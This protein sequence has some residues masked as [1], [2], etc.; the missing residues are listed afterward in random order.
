MNIVYLTTEAIPFARTGGLGDVCGSLPNRVCNLGH[1][2]SVFL[3]AFRS[4]HNAGIPVVPTDISFMIEMKPG[5]PVGCRLLRSELPNSGVTV[6]FIDQPKYFDR[7]ELYGIKSGD[8][9]DNAERFAF[10]S[11]ATIK[12]IQRLQIQPDIVHCNDWQSGLIPGLVRKNDRVSQYFDKTATVMTIHN[13]AYQG[14]FPAKNFEFTGLSWEHFSPNSFEFYQHLNFLKSGIICADTVTT[15]SPQYAAEIKTSRYGCGLE[16]VLKASSS[17][18][19]GIINGIDE[20]IWNPTS[21]TLL[22]YH[23]DAS[24]WLIGKQANKQHLQ[25]KFRLN[26]S[27]SIPLIGLVGRLADQK[28]W[29]L[30]LPVLRWHLQERR[31]TQWVVLGNG[32]PHLENTLKNLANEFPSQLAVHIGFSDPLAHL[33]EAASDIFLMPSH[34]EPCGLNQLYSLRYGSVPIVNPTG[35]L[36]DTVTNTDQHTISQGTATGFHLNHPDPRSLDDAIGVALAT[37]FHQPNTW[38]QIVRTGMQQD[39]SWRRSASQYVNC[40]EESLR[41]RK[42][43]RTSHPN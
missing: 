15:V 36:V 37:R 13:L 25:N 14:H 6:W 26:L 4:I 3:P 29:D 23:Y 20:F 31:P 18:L 41:E 21:D 7:E 22:P 24:N 38:S 43:A 8:Y 16:E 17:R 10:F 2:V 33:I 5:M 28:G 40:Y 32:D 1:T 35:G 9:Q 30:I 39:W 19:K 27:D 34:Y 11:R 42:L 12:A